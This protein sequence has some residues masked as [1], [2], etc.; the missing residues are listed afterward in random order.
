MAG[1]QNVDPKLPEQI[2]DGVDEERRHRHAM[3]SRVINADALVSVLGTAAGVLFVIAALAIA[4]YA[5]SKG[6]AVVAI[7]AIV[8]SLSPVAIALINRGRSRDGD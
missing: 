5:I 4:A 6:S 1:Y 7:A 3:E 8:G 2:M